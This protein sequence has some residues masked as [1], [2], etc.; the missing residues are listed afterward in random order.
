MAGNVCDEY[1]DKCVYY[2]GWGSG[3]KMCN[4]YLMT[5]KR[6]PCDPG[7]GCTVRVLR[8]RKRKTKAEGRG[9]D[10]NQML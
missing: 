2:L 9:E 10:G 5:G 1:C 7:T 4:Y 6:R 8:K 3:T